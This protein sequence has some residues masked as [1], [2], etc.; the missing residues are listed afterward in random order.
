[1]V[2]QK[3][4]KRL[5]LAFLI[6]FPRSSQIF[7]CRSN[8]AFFEKSRD[9]FSIRGNAIYIGVCVVPSMNVRG[10][11]TIF[12]FLFF[13]IKLRLYEICR[14]KIKNCS[15]TRSTIC[16]SQSLIWTDSFSDRIM[17]FLIGETLEI[18]LGKKA[19]FQA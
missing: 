16:V 17:P 2:K 3:R 19:I 9:D 15:K 1:M 8:E 13:H 11:Q 18:Q 4:Q 5:V 12:L 14:T 6:F 7:V 10:L